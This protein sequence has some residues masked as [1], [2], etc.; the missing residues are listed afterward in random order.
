MA[1]WMLSFVSS[2][3]TRSSDGSNP[4]GGSGG[5][6]PANRGTRQSE[7]SVKPSRYST[8]HWGQYMIHLWPKCTAARCFGS[9]AQLRIARDPETGAPGGRGTSTSEYAVIHDQTAGSSP[10]A[11]PRS[12]IP[13]TKSGPVFSSRY[14]RQLIDSARLPRYQNNWTRFVARKPANRF[15]F[16]RLRSTLRKSPGWPAYGDTPRHFVLSAKPTTCRKCPPILSPP[17]HMIRSGG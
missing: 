11:W 13:V 8:R 1:S 10:P 2:T 5:G 3:T 15:F 14:A 6:V 16:N 4:S 9:E 7:Q 12:F 17:R